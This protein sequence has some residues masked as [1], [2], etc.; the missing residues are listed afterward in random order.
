MT[1]ISYSALRQNLR[2]VMD[3]I[4]EDRS[5]YEVSRS[6][7]EPVVMLSKQD[8]DSL[9]ETLYLL[10]NKANADRLHESIQQAESG[11]LVYHS[12]MEE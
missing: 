3:H 11:D 7:Q 1:S 5:V 9:Q 6:G 10:S 4:N 8:Y 12:L 2:S